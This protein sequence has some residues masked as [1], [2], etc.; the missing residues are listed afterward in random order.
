MESSE[1]RIFQAVAQEGS[2]TRAAQALGYVQSNVTARVQQLEAELKK[3]LFYRQ[4]GMVLTPAGEKLL[5]Y[6]ERILNL[7]DEAHKALND[8]PEPEGRLALGAYHTVSYMLLPG[9]LTQYHATYPRVELSLS[10]ESSAALAEKVL[11]YQ[12]DCAF[13][14]SPLH[15]GH[16][17]EELVREEEL[18]LIASPGN[19]SI[20][21]V[22]RRP[23]LMNT[24]GCLHR[25]RLEAWLKLNGIGSVRY[26]EFNHLEAIVG[27][28]I[29][30]LGASLVP[31]SAVEKRVE[32]GQLRAFALPGNTA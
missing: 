29:A 4:R 3:P 18:L 11:H 32:A 23:F 27:G 30:G 13:V 10:T 24:K 22:C 14:L 2:I 5:D 28:V 1:L 19:T 16:I 8:A 17:V 6:S 25:E 9:L 20:E 12:L 31:R 26:M 21:D 15:D 7:L